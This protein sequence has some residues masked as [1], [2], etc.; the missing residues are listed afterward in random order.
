MGPYDVDLLR[1]AAEQRGRAGSSSTGRTSQALMPVELW[2]LMQHRMETY[3][4]ERGKWGFAARRRRW[5]RGCSPSVARPGPVTA[6]DLDD[7]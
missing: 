7:G 5:S 1:R 3:R 2:P 6:R 4:A